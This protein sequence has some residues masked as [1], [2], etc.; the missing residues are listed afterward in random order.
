MSDRRDGEPR[1]GGRGPHEAGF[2]AGGGGA[3]GGP[4]GAPAQ[5]GCRTGGE[6][7]QFRTDGW[8]QCSG[9]EASCW[10]P[11]PPNT[12][13]HP[14][15]AQCHPT[16]QAPGRGQGAGL[17][18]GLTESRVWSPELS[19]LQTLNL[20]LLQGALPGDRLCPGACQEGRFYEQLGLCPATRS[21]RPGPASAKLRAAQGHGAGWEGPSEPGQGLG[22]EAVAG[23]PLRP[24]PPARGLLHG[25]G[26]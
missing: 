21:P 14:H 16:A 6:G 11:R 2:L 3:G 5:P 25:G 17:A 26:G 15:P 24:L 1:A 20:T 12:P 22:S 9:S 4:S 7:V 18:P 13:P 23:L 10:A 8:A 19:A